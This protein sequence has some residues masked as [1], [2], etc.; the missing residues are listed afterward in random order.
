MGNV[1][2]ITM[3]SDDASLMPYSADVVHQSELHQFS[4]TIEDIRRTNEKES[5]VIGSKVEQLNTRVQDINRSCGA[6]DEKFKQLEEF[7]TGAKNSI[8]NL[9]KWQY[10]IEGALAALY[11]FLGLMVYLFREYITKVLFGG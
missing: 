3:S 2:S 5:E 7:R 11:I 4:K 8:A 10:R 9:E 6:Y 1:T